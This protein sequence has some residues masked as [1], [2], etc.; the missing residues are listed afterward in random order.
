MTVRS[1]WTRPEGWWGEWPAGWVNLW[2]P[3]R[4]T[5]E[6]EFNSFF[7]SIREGHSAE[8]SGEDGYLGLEIILAAYLSFHEHRPVRLPLDPDVEVSPPKF[9]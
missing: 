1:S 2:P 7:E 8:V 6:A 4:N 3:R 9:D 5:F